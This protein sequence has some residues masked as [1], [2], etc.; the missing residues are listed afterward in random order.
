MIPT[1]D[2][3]SLF[4]G[5]ALGFLANIGGCIASALLG[6]VFMDGAEPLSVP[7]F[8]VPFGIG[9]AQL[10]WIIPLY[11]RHRKRGTTETAKGL[12]VA[13]AITFLL[14]AACWGVLVSNPLDF[15]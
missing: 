9:L 1:P 13:G 8:A 10:L 3:G 12:L 15:R 4:G 14:N 6:T 5:I 7:F 11:R 2:H